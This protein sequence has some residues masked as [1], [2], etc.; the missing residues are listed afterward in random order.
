MENGEN[1]TPKKKDRG[2]K[3][4]IIA[5]IVICVLLVPLIVINITLVIK[6]STSDGLA[7]IFGYAALTVTSGSMDGDEEDSFPQGSLIIV[8]VLSDEDKQSLQVGDVVTFISGESYVTHRIIYVISSDGVITSV[9]TKGDANTADDGVISI[10]DVKG[11]MTSSLSGLGSF[12]T[13][14]QTPWGI[15]VI[16]GVPVAAYVIYYIVRLTQ[17]NKRRGNGK[18][19]ESELLSEKDEEI[20]RLKEQLAAQSTQPDNEDKEE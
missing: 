11:L 1:T 5:M 6:G 14:M 4:W 3:A 20:R 2:G 12:A 15:V 18:S 7:D 10:E 9:V 17:E 8:K 19:E 16:I 13:F